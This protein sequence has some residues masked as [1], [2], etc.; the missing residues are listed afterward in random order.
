MVSAVRVFVCARAPLPTSRRVSVPREPEGCLNLGASVWEGSLRSGGGE[1]SVH[2]DSISPRGLG[3][4]S[5]LRVRPNAGEGAGLSPETDF[6]SPG[7]ACGADPSAWRGGL[8]EG[9]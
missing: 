2:R 3:G 4:V 9:P 7:E 5:L 8:S 1:G 6:T